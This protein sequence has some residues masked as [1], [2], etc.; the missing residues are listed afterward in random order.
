MPLFKSHCFQCRISNVFPSTLMT[1]YVYQDRN[2]PKNHTEP[3]KVV[4]TFRPHRKQ[5]IGVCV[6]I[7]FFCDGGLTWLLIYR[8][9]LARSS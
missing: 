6:D 2:P 5:G 9:I 8:R 1:R 3:L 7:S 4:L